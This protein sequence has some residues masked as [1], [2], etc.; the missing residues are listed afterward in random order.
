MAASVRRIVDGDGT[1]EIPLWRSP[2]D[3]VRF[4]S[5]ELHEPVA[6]HV[7]GVAE[8]SRVEAQPP[9]RDGGRVPLGT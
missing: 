7:G 9:I 5:L 2:R 8:D 4:T 1:G 3:A 6:Q